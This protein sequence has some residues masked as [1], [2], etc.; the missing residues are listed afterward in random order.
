MNE[1][2]SSSGEIRFRV[3]E[4]E[5]RFVVDGVAT[6]RATLIGV[7][8]SRA[9][10]SLHWGDATR[11]GQWFRSSDSQLA[12]S[13]LWLLRRPGGMLPLDEL[14]RMIPGVQ[15]PGEIVGLVIVTH[16]GLPEELLA[17]GAPAYSGWMITRAGAV[18]FPVHAEP[19]AFGAVQLRGGWPLQALQGDTVSIV[20]TGSIGSAAANALAR[21]G[22][23]QIH[24]IDPDRLL[25]HNVVRHHLG[26]ESVGRF[27]VDALSDAL[28]EHAAGADEST[29]TVFDAHRLDAVTGAE[30]LYPL[31]EES[32]VVLCCA[33]GIAPRR[34]VN[35]LARITRTPAVFACVLDNGSIGELYRS[36]PGRRRGC[37]LCH[38]AWLAKNGWIDPEADQELEYGTGTTHKPMSAIPADLQLVGEFAAQATLATLL[39]AKHGVPG[40]RLPGDHAVI[41]LR[42]TG[43]LAGPYNF[44]F[45]GEVRWTDAPVPRED[46]ATCSIR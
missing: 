31:V 29:A 10:E 36:R 7:R 15:D 44:D 30:D 22:L 4:S 33:D 13:F 39:E 43:D 9:Y 34:V 1:A 40:S 11:W 37:L 45:A 3:L 5:T 8:P 12:A 42:P 28:R 6:S 26:P 32:S 21:V 18:P 20:G 23:G 46:C 19:A 27:K 14:R 2:S 17:A 35:H 16:E 24:L 38:R 25:W 41:G